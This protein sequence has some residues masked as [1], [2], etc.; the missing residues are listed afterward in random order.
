MRG[1]PS[2]TKPVVQ[3][4]CVILLSRNQRRVQV[5][6]H[7]QNT[8]RPSANDLHTQLV[9]QTLEVG[10]L[11]PGFV[12]CFSQRPPICCLCV[13]NGFHFCLTTL[14]TVQ[15]HLSRM[16]L[17]TTLSGTS[18]P[19]C[20][21]ACG[22]S[23]CG[24]SDRGQ[25]CTRDTLPRRFI[26]C[27]GCHKSCQAL[28]E[29]DTAG[30]CKEGLTAALLPNGVFAETARRSMSPVE[31]CTRRSSS[32]IFFDCVLCR[33]IAGRVKIAQRMS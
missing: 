29:H 25:R 2:S 28:A 3:S 7:S 22:R 5:Q 30:Y 8:C 13:A 14:A 6:H 1:N 33:K 23:R 31:S 9:I 17:S 18:S 12:V 10:L 26:I 21:V 19:A 16:I 32:R 27:G 20:M 11:K 15:A 4:G 24:L